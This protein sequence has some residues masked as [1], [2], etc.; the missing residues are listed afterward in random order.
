MRAPPPPLRPRP[1]QRRSSP[2][3]SWGN[4]RANGYQALA[5]DGYAQLAER[6]RMGARGEGLITRLWT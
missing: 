2:S 4:R 1:A 5:E 6:L 3:R